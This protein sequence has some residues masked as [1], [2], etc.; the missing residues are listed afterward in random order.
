MAGACAALEAARAGADVLIVERFSGC[1][2]TSAVAGG[3]FYL[4]GGT[5]V[6]RACGIEDSAEEMEKFLNAITPTP[7]P[8]KIHAYAF[9]SVS[10]FD[11]LESQGIPFER[12]FY[13]HKTIMQPGSEGLIWSGNEE[14][15]PYR[16]QAR[17]APRGH[18]VKF[19]EG[20]GGGGFALRFLA[21]RN[22]AA[23]VRLLT[24]ARVDALIEGPDGIVGVRA[25]AVGGAVRHIRARRGVVLA[26]GGFGQNRAM[27]EQHI[28]DYAAV[29]DRVWFVGAP[30]D[31]GSA[32]RLGQSAGGHA[33]HMSELFATCYFYPPE[34]LLKG[35]LVNREGRRFVTEDSYHSRTAV[36]VARQPAGIA[37]LILDSDI[38]A[39][40]ANQKRM[41]Q[42]LIDGWETV[43][44][45][46][47]GLGLP[48]GSLI[49][50]I[51]EYNADCEAGGDRAFGKH[52][53]RLKPLTAAP[54][55]AF[56][57]SF[58]RARYRAFTLGGL[59]TALDGEVVDRD[60]ATIPGLFAAGG[61]SSNVAQE[62][63]NYASGTC[64]GQASYFGRRAGFAAANRG[65]ASPRAWGA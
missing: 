50:T 21:E 15:Y 14:V 7:I 39:Y 52:P 58:G 25:L 26:G 57:V 5:P 40:P 13:P 24:D 1:G 32:I 20:E 56:D 65:V 37:Y 38:F 29:G 27:V 35:I 16:D 61:C 44:E 3:H 60:G 12:S 11:W 41:E 55:A 10:H 34:D 33:I 54:F 30:G 49:G 42:E 62:S 6:Q 43:E 31:D 19:V 51:A 46:E 59:Q 28:P 9:D 22:E 23:G 36:N 64:L 2:G 48:E 63:E 17:P 8:D 18:K 53:K 47:A 45:M 4:G